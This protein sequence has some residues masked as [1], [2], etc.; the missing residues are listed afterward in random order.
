MF[1]RF[2]SSLNNN[3][4]QNLFEMIKNTYAEM[5]FNKFYTF[6]ILPDPLKK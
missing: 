4:N 6:A 3:N 2:H 5:N 1:R